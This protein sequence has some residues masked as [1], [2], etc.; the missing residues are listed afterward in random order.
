MA[1]TL[2]RACGSSSRARARSSPRR[3]TADARAPAQSPATNAVDADLRDAATA[4]PARRSRSTISRC[5]AKCARARRSS[6]AVCRVARPNI[7]IQPAGPDLARAAQLAGVACYAGWA[8]VA[9]GRS[10]SP[11][12]ISGRGRCELHE[13]PTGRRIRRFTHWQMAIHWTTAYRVRRAR[14]HRADHACS[15]RTCCCR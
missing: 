2:H 6:R 12:S 9:D 1:L 4:A 14:D 10:S 15:A 8:L 3:G 7:L 13:P 5:G 11:R